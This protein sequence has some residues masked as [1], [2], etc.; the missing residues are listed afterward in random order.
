MSG[1]ER[2]P[3]SVGGN[4]ALDFVNTDVYFQGDTTDIV[5]SAAELHAWHAYAGGTPGASDDDGTLL[6]DAAALRSALRVIVESL[7][8]GRSPGSEP[9]A[10]L[11]TAYA[12]AVRRAE[13]TIDDGHLAWRTARGGPRAGLDEIADAAV[14]LLSTAPAG[15]LKVCPGCG[16]VFLDTTRN[17]S[18]RWCAMEDCGTAEKMRRY[19]TKRAAA[20]S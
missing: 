4:L 8:A 14:R 17:G 7:A 1:S 16:F 10:R 11:Q 15:R 19:V 9:L 2:W 20:R 18:R 5:R 6:R 12:G 3:K 13:P